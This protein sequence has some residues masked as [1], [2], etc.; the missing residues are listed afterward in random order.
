MREPIENTKK[1]IHENS[2]LLLYSQESKS[3]DS[4]SRRPTA[5]L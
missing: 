5:R 3:I 2:P 1:Y 4:I